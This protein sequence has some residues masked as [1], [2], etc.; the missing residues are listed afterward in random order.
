MTDSYVNDFFLQAHAGLQ[1]TARP[2]RY[3]VLYDEL[4]MGAD[5]LQRFTHQLCYL[6]PRATKAISLC[7]PAYLAD[8]ACERA[9]YWLYHTLVDNLGGATDATDDGGVSEWNDE[10]VH[11]RLRNSTFYI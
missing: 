5:A 8:R 11:A 10:A 6:F 2:A 9:R 7:P 1:G 4:K 3:V